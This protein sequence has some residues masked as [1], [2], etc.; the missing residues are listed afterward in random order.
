MRA[1]DTNALAQAGVVEDCVTKP[2]Q[3]YCFPRGRG[4]KHPGNG[5]LASPFNKAMAELAS[6]E[7]IRRILK[8]GKHTGFNLID[9][10]L[11]GLATETCTNATHGT[12]ATHLCCDHFVATFEPSKKAMESARLRYGPDDPVWVVHGATVGVDDML[13]LDD[14]PESEREK[15]RS[16]YE[17]EKG[18]LKASQPQLAAFCAG[19]KPDVVVM[20]GFGYAAWAEFAVVLERCRPPWLALHNMGTLQART[21]RNYVSKNP[22][23]FVLMANDQSDPEGWA[24]FAVNAEEVAGL[25]QIHEYPRVNDGLFKP[26]QRFRRLRATRT[27]SVPSG[28]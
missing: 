13:A 11:Q 18:L 27:A 24:I 2:A 15:H 17:R 10:M 3:P 16:E 12:H 25:K 5:H 21:V 20:D 7:G 28:A 14:L 23:K 9:D 4:V 22:A 6:R 8:I 26:G 1:I 19:V